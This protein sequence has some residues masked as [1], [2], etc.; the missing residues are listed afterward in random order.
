MPLPRLIHPIDVVVQ[1]RDLGKTFVDDDFREPI[2][3]AARK[4]NVII[5]GQIKFFTQEELNLERGGTQI[6]STGFVLFRYFDLNALGVTVGIGDRFIKLGKIDVDYY[7][8]RVES[9]GHWPDQGGATLVRCY[10]QDRTPS[11]QNAGKF[12]RQ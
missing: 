9:K 8:D 2:Q 4:T 1:R 11:K 5:K 3:Q 7:V 10:F 12:P 6:D